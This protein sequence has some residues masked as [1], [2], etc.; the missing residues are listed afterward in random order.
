MNRYTYLLAAAGLLTFGTSC[1]KEY[2]CECYNQWTR[3]RYVETIKD[4]KK[5][6]KATC[7]KMDDN[8]MADGPKDCVFMN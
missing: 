6:A 1:K 8:Y 5:N 3:S 2:K 4:T 7:D